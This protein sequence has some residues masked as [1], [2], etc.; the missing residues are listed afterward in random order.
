MQSRARLGNES[1]R[2]LSR[3][4]HVHRNG[5]SP[6][7]KKAR[8]DVQMGAADMESV[9]RLTPMDEKYQRIVKL[10]LLGC[11]ITEVFFPARVTMA[12]N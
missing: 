10:V 7:N 9:T 11:D 8:G 4:D 5:E 6:E 1:Q 2:L 12:C 3:D